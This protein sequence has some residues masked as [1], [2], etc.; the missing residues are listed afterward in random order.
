MADLVEGIHHK[1]YQPQSHIRSA[2]YYSLLH[3]GLDAVLT[4]KTPLL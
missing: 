3:P 1:I 2:V 4:P